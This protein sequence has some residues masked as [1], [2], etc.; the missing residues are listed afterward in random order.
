E[1]GGDR[2]AS[3]SGLDGVEAVLEVAVAFAAGRSGLAPPC[4]RQRPFGIAPAWHE[5]PRRGRAPPRGLEGIG[6]RL[7]MGLPPGTSC[8]PPPPGLPRI[9]RWP[10]HP[11]AR[12][13]ARPQPSAAPCCGSD[14]GPRAGP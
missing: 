9:P 5:P 2:P 10:G 3:L 13:R 12:G 8:L 4:I 6:R 1:E 7:R 14:E 11:R